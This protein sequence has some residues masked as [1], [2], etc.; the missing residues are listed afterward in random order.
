MR[1]YSRTEFPFRDLRVFIWAGPSLETQTEGHSIDRSGV[2]RPKR[3]ALGQRSSL[4]GSGCGRSR[5]EEVFVD[6][7]ELANSAAEMTRL[8]SAAVT[9]TVDAP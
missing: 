4:Q 5:S 3:V 1:L 8:G 6:K 2:A 9:D 7:P